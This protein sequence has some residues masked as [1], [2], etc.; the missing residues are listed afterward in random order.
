MFIKKVIFK[1]C[2]YRLDTHVYVR[3]NTSRIVYCIPNTLSIAVAMK[4]AGTGIILKAC[5]VSL[6]PIQV[7]S[8]E[9]T[10]RTDLIFNLDFFGPSV[11]A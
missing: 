1:L 7:Y 11:T 2:V 10:G 6:D 9:C 4:A 5:L 8:P 3:E